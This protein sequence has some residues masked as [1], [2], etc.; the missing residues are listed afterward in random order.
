MLEFDAQ[1]L[2]VELGS[3]TCP[4]FQSRRRKM[5]ELQQFGDQVDSV[6][7]YVREAHPGADIPAHRG[8]D[9]KTACARWL[10]DDGE[11]RNV[12]VDDLEGTAHRA[13][14]GLPNSVFIIN[15][16]GCVVFKSDWND[17]SATFKALVALLS[18]RPVRARSFF[19]PAVPTI[20]FRTLRQAGLGSGR[21]FLKSFPSLVWNNLIKRNI[22]VLFN[23]PE[24]GEGD[25]TC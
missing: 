7:L 19:R 17:P 25:M 23:R 14:G 2:V 18:N 12:L 8:M 15:R 22:R 4:L 5:N 10:V 3:I 24:T 16:S 11:S 20:A 9:N 21:D 13:F 1:F 6:V